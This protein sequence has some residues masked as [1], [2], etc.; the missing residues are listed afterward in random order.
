MSTSQHSTKVTTEQLVKSNIMLAALAL[1]VIRLHKAGKATEAEAE[2]RAVL[3][4][5]GE[6]V[7]SGLD[8]LI[9]GLCL[10]D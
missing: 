6:S 1:R 9:A 7:R 8:Q 4:N 2:Y 10:L 3:S 5:Y